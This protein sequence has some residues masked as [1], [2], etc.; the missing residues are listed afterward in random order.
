MGKLLF[1]FDWKFHKGGAIGA[2]AYTYDDA[3]WRNLHLPHD[4]SIEDLGNT[5]SPFTESAVAQSWSGFTVGG[6]AWYRKHFNV[7][8]KEKGKK[9]FIT[10]DGV[11]MNSSVWLNGKPLGGNAYGYS[12]FSFDI[13]ELIHFDKPNIIAIKVSNEGETS[14]WYSGSGIYRHVWLE[15]KN[16]V[17]LSRWGTFITT[18]VIEQN[19][20]ITHIQTKIKN[21]SSG[22]S[23]VKL[24]SIIADKNGIEVSRAT[25][26]ASVKG[27]TE[28]GFEQSIH[29]KKFNRWSVDDPYLYTLI[30]KVY[31]GNKL[32]DSSATKFGI[33]SLKFSTEGFAL[34]GSPLKL[35][36][37]C[38]HHDNGPL[39]A[40]AFDRAEERK[41]EILKS[42]GYNAVRTSHNPPSHAF[43]DACDRLGMLVIDEAFDCWREGKNPYDYSLYFDKNWK[44]DIDAMVL[45]DRNHPSII[46]WSSGNEIPNRQKPEVAEVSK[47]ISSYIKSLDTT[48]PVTSAVNELSPNKDLY[49]STID[50]A[51]YNYAAGGDHLKDDVFSEDHK[52]VPARIMY[53]AEAY[54]FEAYDSWKK[55]L[56][57]P[58]VLGAFVWTAFDYIGE[59]S[60][61]WR[62]YWPDKNIFPWTLAYCGDI[63]ICGN[64]RPAAYYREALWKKNQLSL[65]VTPP[66]STFPLNASKEDW[67]KWHW[68]DVVQS[69][70]H[71][72]FENKL[73]D[74]SAYSSC[75]EVELFF[76]NKSL[77][78]K[79]TNFSVKHSA[80]WQVP[81]AAGTLKAIGYS[82]N[83]PVSESALQTSGKTNAIK[84]TADR[85]KITADGQDLSYVQINLTD[86]KGVINPNAENLVKFELDGPGEIIGVGNGKPTSLESYQLPQRKAWQGQCLVIIKSTREAGT[87]TLKAKSDGMPEARVTIQAVDK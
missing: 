85:S 69:W 31:Q 3:T 33:R 19:K 72:G 20:A 58:Y 64:K 86:A 26:E 17:H 51:G 57:K 18:P 44:K 35:K 62:G 21:S 49:F 60:I 82:G 25:E 39:G 56:E 59:A 81:Y 47:M 43:L 27:G 10:F 54:P 29:L 16:P 80:T 75:D 12:E 71:E 61:G 50:I 36:G 4:W 65:F 73:L 15:T 30:S 24:I 23:V 87:V 6:T 67:S 63:D 8:P 55:V 7:S 28:A 22:E 37:G 32:V 78:R 76:N 40:K 83:K 14:R 38:L 66:V 48:R 11:Y 77:G 34:N 52:R 46:M 45:R 1:N 2:E 42:A 5:G 68:H 74:V 13:S 9:F 70:N 79:P 53:E 84:M 41:V